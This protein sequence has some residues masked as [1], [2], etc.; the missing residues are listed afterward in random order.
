MQE[1]AAEH[2]YPQ[3]RT[4]LNGYGQ[5]QNAMWLDARRTS[6]P[7]QQRVADQSEAMTA[8][9]GITYNKG[10]ALIRMLENY[11]GEDAFR[12]GIRSYMAAHG[13]D[14]TTTADLWQALET[15]AGKPVK[16]IA[17]SFTK[18]DGVPLII[19]ETTCDG[20]T[21]RL[22]LRQD[23]FAIAP[24]S[25][26]DG[27][28]L[29]PRSWQVPIE[30]G[31]LNSKQPAQTLLLEGSTEIAAGACGE[32]IKVN[33]GDIG[34]YRVEYGPRD[35]AALTTSL[36][37][38]TPEDR[39][40]F[41]A[42]RW[43]LVQA[44]RAELPSYLEL[45]DKINVN[46]RRAVWDQV[47]NVL[48][49]LDHLAG[50]QPERPALQAYARAQ[51]RPPFDRL[52]WDATAPANDEQTLLRSRLILTL[53]DLGD[54]DILAEARRR[55]AGF[56]QNPQSLPAALR[57]AVTHVVGGGADSASYDALLTLARSSTVTT[58]RV[59]YYCAAASARDATLARATLALT[60]TGELPNTIVNRVINIVAFSGEQPQ[61]AWDFVQQN[62]DALT[63]KQGPSFR[64]AFIPDLM[65]NF[66]DEAH[67][68]ELAHFAPALATSGGRVMV[69]RS[70][71]TIAI[72]ADLK[73]RA[74][75]AFDAW[76]KT[77]NGTRP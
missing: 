72:S 12:A 48:T 62:L 52:G 58:D 76:V 61:L 34:Y 44:G 68:A 2:F 77:H 13:Y 31:P 50:G 67:A 57:D 14:N 65:T 25:T 36:G 15:A 28:P 75:P 27:K 54:P 66:S 35:L 56:V 9:D 46:D 29:A 55:F 26:G 6:H 51:L 19:A 4:W 45:V 18:Q 8:F 37:Q 3:W 33:L 41:L 71:E 47:I 49:W 74:L 70:L 10:Q 63:A 32:P 20:A 1:K 24:V 40:N 5:K 7:I 38:M 69:T 16:G 60:L 42:D 64:D 30:V 43:A 39:V 73:A 59:R 53:G 11:L 17:A 23:R 22:S 21:Q